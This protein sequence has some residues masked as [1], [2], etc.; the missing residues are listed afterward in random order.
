MSTYLVGDIQGCFDD[1]CDL[2]EQAEFNPQQDEL[3]LSGDLVARGPKSLETLRFVKELGDRATTVLGNHDLHLLAAANGLAKAKSR[4][5][6]QPILDAPDRDELLEWLR[7]Q[8]LLAEHPQHPFAMAHAGISPQW[9]LTTARQQAK[10]VEACL[11]SD[12]Y[13]WL[14]ENMYGNG[15]DYWTP[16]LS[17]IEQYRYTINAFTRMRF[18]YPDGRLD[19]DCKL[20][21]EHPET[22]PLQPWFELPRQQPLGKKVIFGHWA[23]LM[24]HEDQH[25][26][27][28]D[29]GCVW[30]NSMTLLR[31]EDGARFVKP[32]P[33]H[34]E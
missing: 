18:C 23:A 22:G 24:G 5:K 12:D 21:P 8:P 7:R 34:A 29:T 14:L 3:W 28:L 13:L 31:W 33:V 1:L 6:V 27:G 16:V 17:G 4:D 20:S 19:M 15:P 32:C 9:D 2:L 30:G 11:Q 25:V 10:E 26:I